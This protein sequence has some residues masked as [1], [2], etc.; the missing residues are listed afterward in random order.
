MTTSTLVIVDETVSTQ[1][2]AK[3]LWARGAPNG[4]AVC[5]RRQTGARGRRGRAFVAGH[6]GVWLSVVIRPDRPIPALFAPRLSLCVGVF[7]MD[8]LVTV[9]ADAW[10]K[11]PNDLVVPANTQAPRLG[12]YRKVGG[13]LVEAIDLDGGGLR[14]AVVGV[15]INLTMPSDPELAAVASVLVGHTDAVA[16]AEVIRTAV[17]AAATT[18]DVGFDTV[19][20][21]AAARSA[22]LGRV[23]AVDDVHGTAVAL[24]TDGALVVESEGR[25]VTVSAGDVGVLG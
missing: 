7:V 1:D 6:D 9:G 12:P 14:A 5:A 25:R 18:T 20:E 11:W 3:A 8:A 21:R 23:V 24:D 13:V 10:L 22:T 2:D 15:G 4:T 19:V 16:L 17:V